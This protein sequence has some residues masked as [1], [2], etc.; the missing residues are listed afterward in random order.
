[1]ASNYTD[2]DTERVRQT[3]HSSAGLPTQSLGVG[4]IASPPVPAAAPG[5]NNNVAALALI[6][7]GVVMLLGRFAPLRLELEGGMILLTIA[8]CFLFFSF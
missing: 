1:M 7:I 8:S 3:E 2:Q 5:R 6:A 4:P